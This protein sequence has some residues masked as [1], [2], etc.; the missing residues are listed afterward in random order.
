MRELSTCLLLL[1]VLSS[2]AIA[3]APAADRWI[4]EAAQKQLSEQ[5]QWHRLLH[6][7]PGNTSSDVT[8]PEFFLAPSGQHSSSDEL[9]ATIEALLREPGANPDGHAACRFPARR[10][11]LEKMLPGIPVGGNGNL[12]CPQYER[13]AELGSLRSVS[14]MM[15]SGYLGNPASSFGHSLL[16]LNRGDRSPSSELLDTSLNFGAMVPPKELAAIYIYRGLTGGYQAGFSDKPFYSED[17]VYS[18]TEFRDMWEYELDLSADQRTLLVAHIWEVTGKKFTYFFLSKNCAFR[19]AEL[20]DIAADRSDTPAARVWY[21][22]V[23]LFHGLDA[24]R[25]EDSRPLVTGV[26]FR[27]STQRILR[28]EFRRLDTAGVASA[29][30]LI[31]S[32]LDT[33]PRELQSLPKDS[34]QDIIDTV[35]AYYAY[36][37][38][39]EERAEEQ[40]D[41]ALSEARAALLRARF[42]YPPRRLE[43][44]KVQPLPPP[45]QFPA[46]MLAGLGMA[47]TE[48]DGRGLFRYAAYSQDIMGSSGAEFRELV[49]LDVTASLSEHGTGRLESLDLI[50]LRKHELD[51]APIQNDDPWSWQ[52]RVGAGRDL[53]ADSPL[54]FDGSAGFGRSWRTFPSGMAYLFLESHAN[55]GTDSVDFVPDLGFA[56]RYRQ[57]NYWIEGGPA[58]D[59]RDS[60]W[61][62]YARAQLRWNLRRNLAVE[63]QYRLHGN[64]QAA[65]LSVLAFF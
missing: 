38:A 54:G 41:P 47:A 37:L 51:P 17:Q 19:I 1:L 39:S 10:L 60:E 8:S 20:L 48:A 26:Q 25:L 14:M 53:A 2:P 63:T 18:H 3:G 64:D 30:R 4:A 13:W 24:I 46:P 34:A 6:V 11:W 40:I 35:L 9:S 29:L 28:E 56:G 32:P 15:V 42:S 57:W 59:L 50:R 65:S 7:R 33:L 31:E 27:P 52:L 43:P 61:Q 49:V 16:K 36:R 23:E 58:Y 12:H 22:P 5:P 45:H 44:P 55:T 21:A 62:P